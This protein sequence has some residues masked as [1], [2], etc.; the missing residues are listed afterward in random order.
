M[1]SR[2]IRFPRQ[3]Q[4]LLSSAVNYPFWSSLQ[5]LFL[6][7]ETSCIELTQIYPQRKFFLFM[8]LDPKFW[9]RQKGLRMIFQQHYF[10][11]SL[12][13]QPSSRSLWLKLET[14]KCNPKAVTSAKN[15]NEMLFSNLCDVDPMFGQISEAGWIMGRSSV[16]QSY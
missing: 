7:W 5:M 10:L 14:L 6:F 13:C 15:S 11:S 4:E 8:L 2:Q 9:K 16:R 12:K 3:Y 1:V